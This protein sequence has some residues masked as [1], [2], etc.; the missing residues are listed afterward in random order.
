MIYLDYAIFI[1]LF[2]IGNIVGSFCNVCIYRLPRQ[3]SIIFPGSHC[4]H[5]Q[6]PIYWYDNI[7]LLS[8]LLLRG[9][10]RTC[11]Q[12]ISWHYP[13]VEFVSGVNLL[14]F[15]WLF[16]LSTP[17]FIYVFLTTALI[18]ITFI[19]LEHKIIPDIITLPGIP[20]GIL[21]STLLLQQSLWDSLMGILLGGGI[22]YLVALLSRGGMGGGDIELGAMIGAFIGWRYILLTIFVAV[23]SGSI[24]SI[25]LLIAGKK[26]RKDMVPFGPFLALGT[27]VSILWGETIIH[28]YLAWHY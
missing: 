2:I 28:W 11:S 19:D 20:L 24:I 14:T 21:F 17:F 22:F 1:Y 5:C 18:I 8:F 25:A 6:T 7:P 16:S 23:F 15:Y 9:K 27:F 10:C 26:G 3:E 4:P 12:P 13:L